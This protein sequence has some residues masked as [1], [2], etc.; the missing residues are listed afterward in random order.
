[1]GLR[2]MATEQP[3]HRSEPSI[4]R[5]PLRWLLVTLGLVTAALGL[6]GAFLPI[7]PTTPFL[8][9]AG[10]CFARSSPELHRR[11]LAMRAFGPYLEQWQREHT[12]PPEAK[13]RAY[14]L[15]V[16]T[17]AVSIWLV[18]ATGLRILIAAIGVALLAF[19]ASLPVGTRGSAAG[20]VRTPYGAEEG[21]REEPESP[22]TRPLEQKTR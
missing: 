18:D 2:P 3:E 14:G 12:V 9:V 19:L 10:A 8:L 6:L 16:V 5:G 20:G 17:F 11:M 15:V 4:P 1:M 21:T 22:E 7:L 13:R